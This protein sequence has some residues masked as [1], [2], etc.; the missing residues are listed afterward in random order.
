MKSRILKMAFCGVKVG[1]TKVF[2]KHWTKFDHKD[3]TQSHSQNMAKGV[4]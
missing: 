4:S 2:W 3:L 1:N